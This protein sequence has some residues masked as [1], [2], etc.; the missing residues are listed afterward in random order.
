MNSINYPKYSKEHLKNFDELPSA[1]LINAFN[2]EGKLE[3][4]YSN[5]FLA[6]SLGYEHEELQEIL[7]KEVFALIYGAD[8]KKTMQARE[9]VLNGEVVNSITRQ[10]RKDGSPVW[11]LAHI[12]MIEIDG[13]A[14]MFFL[15]S[16]IQ[17]LI[18]L[19]D[20]LTKKNATWNDIIES[21]PI[22]ICVFRE[23]K[24]IRTT[25]SINKNLVNVANSAGMQIDNKR[26]EWTEAEL[27]MV[28]NKDLYAFCENEDIPL[29]QKMFVECEDSPLAT[30]V[31]R[32]HGSSLGNVVY[33][34]VTCSVK[35]ADDGSRT[36]Y[37]TLQNVTKEEN[38]RRELFKKQAQL[39]ELSY[40]D[41]MTG[42]KNRNAY[43][44]YVV[45]CKKNKIH[46]VGFAFCDLNGLKTVNDTIGHLYGDQMIKHFT[47]ILKE[48]FYNDNIYRISGDEFIIIS[49]DTDRFAFQ[50]KMGELID[51]MRS[52]D[53]LA[54]IGFIWKK[55]VS[56]IPRRAQQA[57]QLMYVEKQRYYEASRNISS[58]HR[59]QIL[60][61]LLQNFEDGCFVMYLQPKTSIDGSKVIGAEAL[62]RKIDA[63]GN[64][65]APYEFV[66]QLE[67][68]KLI[69]KLDFYIMEQA[70]KFLQEQHQRG[71][72]DFAVSVNV[73][74]VTIVENEF[75]ETVR[76][77]IKKYDFISSNLE[78]EL[79]ESNKTMDSI[80]LEE[81]IVEL[82]KMNIKV[83]IDDMGTEYSTLALLTLD[84]INWVKLDR[85]L[86]THL[87]QGKDRTLLKHIINMCHDLGLQVIAE[88][89]E[90]DDVRM[91]LMEMGCDAYQGYL[92]SKPIP[93]S[94][95][96]EFYCC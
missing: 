72:D 56:D 74:R 16:R 64:I 3:Y 61:S 43:N 50:N 38:Y 83:S 84:G 39:Y 66:P 29:L 82:K 11:I 40:Y 59:P 58:K 55:E 51:R 57:E 21:I 9:K 91:Q 22:G 28:L 13:H 92:T 5:P 94:E 1:V 93:V 67:R 12:R 36:Y 69:P 20:E 25:L 71:N 85:S 52:E 23:Y 24:G 42:I 33:I 26:R 75:M 63:R 87:G 18:G 34:R 48:Y 49:P 76:S 47:G 80:R 14:G 68:E 95:F 27:G 77:I 70:C 31:F 96:K 44:D 89:V 78:I 46:D 30:G 65:I 17:E 86:V 45:Y 37:M 7:S 8:R 54:S 60:E 81:Y 79:T 62:A 4:A 19:Q 35:H 10:V 73:S 90:T 88:G 15:F 2:D 41:S 53:N 32:L 6:K